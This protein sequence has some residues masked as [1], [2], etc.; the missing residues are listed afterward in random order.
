MATAIKT[1][2]DVT[3]A[4]KKRLFVLIS[5]IL[6]MATVLL[7]YHALTRF[8]HSLTPELS[9]KAAEIG[10]TVNRDITRA[11]G[12]GIPF[13]NM[14]NVEGY[15]KSVL[16]R[17]S[18]L[19]YLA[20]TDKTGEILFKT[21]NVGNAET[22]HFKSAFALAVVKSK[23]T[24][25]QRNLET[26][27]DLSIRLSAGE[28]ALGVLHI[29]VDKNFIQRQLDD[30][31]YDL[32]I[33][34]IV[35]LLVAIEITLALITF[36]VTGPLDRLNRL[37]ALYEKGDFSQFIVYTGK[38]AI[39]SVADYLT[40]STQRLNEKY[41]SVTQSVRDAT[42]PQRAKIEEIGQKYKLGNLSKFFEG[43]IVDAR[44]PLFIFSFAEELQK[45]F[46]PLFVNEVYTPVPYL[47]KEVVI[48]LPIAIFMGI[49]ALATPFAGGW[50]DKYGSRRIFVAGLIP[51]VA[52]YIGCALATTIYEV[53]IWRGL[54]GLGY[55]MITISCQGYIAA[56]ITRENRAQGMAVF[57]GVL[58]SASMCGTAIGGILADRIGFRLVFALAAIFA[59]V[60]GFI[61]Y[62]MMV[63]DERTVLPAAKQGGT[64]KKILSLRKNLRFV[65][66]VF[67][68]AIPAKIILTGF[69]YFL[70]P[71]Y[72]VTL[73]ST[74]AE[75]GRVMMIYPIIIIALGPA[76]SWTADK[77]GNM[78]WML[79]VGC[80]ISGI[81]LV[82][83]HELNSIWGV[84]LMVV[85]M[86][87]AH[88]FTKA[89]QIAFVMELCEEDMERIGR[90]TVL[91][92]LR[93]MERIGS[94]LGPIIAATFVTLYGY[95][96]AIAGTGAVVSASAILF[97][98]IF[99][100]TAKSVASKAEGK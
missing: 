90:T 56:I 35:A 27:H 98:I 69:L 41:Q 30:I 22:N 9:K 76:A 61:A 42:A 68:A 62:R 24:N 60:A 66:V 91:G 63:A 77:L 51:A 78:M 99:L 19:T 70:L 93:T 34:L 6:V 33:I 18:E 25:A 67:L 97:L 38:D 49:I 100:I 45:S 47:T 59:L 5:I 84:V 74:P 26:T 15:L 72:M 64:F 3:A 81:G 52:G 14:V 20:V 82:A 39:G 75:I 43:G 79:V 13:K 87:S 12:Y 23:S 11:V 31:F 8:E 29:G 71:L 95:E 80:F 86:G 44:I 10:Q 92:L 4:T 32:L 55:A 7:S 37:M 85:I 65:A 2:V 83:F 36:Y 16:A 53:A 89:P 54:T 57:V 1:E 58:M 73:G 17:Y 94:V 28:T 48:G 40:S 96:K 50:A 21:G 88:A 46:M